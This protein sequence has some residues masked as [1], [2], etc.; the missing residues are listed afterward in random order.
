MELRVLIHVGNRWW[1]SNSVDGFVGILIRLVAKSIKPMKPNRVASGSGNG[2]ISNKSFA[3]LPRAAL[4]Q[5]S[6][7]E[8]LH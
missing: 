2:P 4:S 5:G 8:Y 3:R 6:D 1:F 7:F